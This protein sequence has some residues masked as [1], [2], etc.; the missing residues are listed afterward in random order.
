MFTQF[1]LY[2]YGIIAAIVA[3]FIG[4]FKLRG[5]KIEEQ[6]KE[7]KQQKQNLEAVEQYHE[8]KDKV[9]EFETQNKVAAEKAKHV[10]K[11]SDISDGNY[12]L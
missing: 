10:E 7:I 2:A 6:E 9:Q 3:F 4:W 5:D 12:K 8:A 11:Q 1:K